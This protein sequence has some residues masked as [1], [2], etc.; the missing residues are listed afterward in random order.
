MAF[1]EKKRRRLLIPAAVV[2]LRLAEVD[3]LGT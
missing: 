3:S 1:G 2:V